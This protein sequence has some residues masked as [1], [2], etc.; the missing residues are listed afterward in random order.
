MTQ[1]KT[2]ERLLQINTDDRSSAFLFGPRGT[3]KT[4]WI[5]SQ[6][7]D[8]L[9]LDL[10]DTSL[11]NQLL[12]NPS[13]LKSLIPPKFEHYIVIDEVQKIPGLL[14]EVHRLIESNH[15]RFV[16][17]GSSARSLK[18]QGVNLLAGRALNYTMHPFTCYELKED[19]S[20]TKA[21]TDGLLPYV[22]HTTHSTQYLETY[23]TT[24]LREEVLQEG[25]LRQL[26]QF[27]R[28]LETASFS[29]GQPVN[30]SEI[31][32]ETGIDR[33]VT[34]NYFT[35]LE[36]LLIGYWLPA[37]TK[38][39][40]RR[41]IAHPKFYLFDSGVYRTLRPKGP[42][43]SP[44]EIDGA[45]L[46]TLFLAHLRAVNDYFHL[47]YS[48]YFWRTSNQQEVDFIAYGENGLFAFEIKRSKNLSKNDL[49]GLRAFKADYPEAQC[50]LLYGGEQEI[51][52]DD[53][54]I[55]PFES[56]L[57]KLIEILNNKK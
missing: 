31:A 30:Y 1:F 5:K 22:Y 6:L 32:R 18:R 24:Y 45:A 36:D 13:R 23:I 47:R 44:Q 10:L 8:I 49:S 11:Y 12:A 41:V 25:L 29:Q 51:Y 19:F 14:N 34:A 37:F 4:S 53:I 42:L 2:Y 27:A 21:L 43:D 17:T 28:F 56:G 50:Y 46:E 54:Q 48:F 57:K 39:A 26:N 35:I 15:Y 33:K 16:L 7:K 52:Q 40:K 38:R 20:L 3:G 55:L 9:Y